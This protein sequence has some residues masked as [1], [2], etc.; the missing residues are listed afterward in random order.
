MQVYISN[1]EIAQIAEGV[2]YACCG[3]SPPKQIN[4]DAVASFLGLPVVYEQIAEEDKDKIGFTSNGREPLAVYRSGRKE[5]VLF[6]KDVIV[7]EKLLLNPSEANRRRFTLAH[8]IGHVLIGRATP[9]QTDA[10]FNR[11]YD[12]EREYNLAELHDRMS[13]EECQANSMAAMILMP[14][15]VLSDAVY[16]Y[17]HR[18]KIP[19]YGDCVFLPKMKPALQ[20]MS[21]ELGVSYSAML[22]QLKKYGLL[23]YRNMQEYFLKTMPSGGEA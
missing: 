16:R 11:V 17:I 18:K 23:E 14:Y 5:S 6:P 3:E 7:L 2:V 20:S 21:E 13:L 15:I 1:K 12:T 4:I 22:I 8:E 10:C 9:G 19:I